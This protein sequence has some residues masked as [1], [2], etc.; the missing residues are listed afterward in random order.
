MWLS[1]RGSGTYYC[2]LLGDCTVWHIAYG[3]ALFY[4]FCRRLLCLITLAFLIITGLIT[5]VWLPFFVND[6][7]DSSTIPNVCLILYFLVPCGFR[8]L[9]SAYCMWDTR[10]WHFALPRAQHLIRLLCE[11]KPWPWGYASTAKSAGQSA[12]LIRLDSFLLTHFGFAYFHFFGM[13]LRVIAVMLLLSR[14]SVP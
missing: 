2:P 7:Q 14:F 10:C 12:I 6:T 4:C 8:W 5:R 9:Q 13:A 3:I 11:H 1:F